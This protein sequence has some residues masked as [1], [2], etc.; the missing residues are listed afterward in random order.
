MSRELLRP[1]E[2]YQKARINFVQ[3][4][5]D[6][7]SKSQNIEALNAA[8]VMA[9]LRPLLLDTVPSIQQSAALAIG[10]L[11][12]YS[13][14]LATS[15]VENN[16]IP[17]LIF[18]LSKPNKFFKKVTC[19]VFK[20]VAKHSALL[21][22]EVVK[23][24]ALEP[25]V[26]CLDEFDTGV[27]EAAS[28]AL[29]F[30]AKHSPELAHKVIQARAVDSLVL[31]LQEPDL[32]LKRA[33][34]L[35]LSYI[36][37]HSEQLAKPVAEFGLDTIIFFLSY[38]DTQLK[39]NICQL[40]GNIARHSA[41]LAAQIIARIQNPQ[42]LLNCLKYPDDIVKKNAAFC[43]CELVNK[44][45]ENAQV[46]CDS[47]GAGILVDYITNVKGDARLYGILALGFIASFKKELAWTVIEAKA[48]NQLF[49]ALHNEINPQIKAAA[50]YSLGHIGRHSTKHAKEVSDANVLSLMLYY[51][52]DKK[53]NDYLRNKAKSS[54]KKII[55]NCDNLSA[56]EPLLQVSP[57]KILKHILN[58][59]IKY[60]KTNNTELKNFI[61][62]G[63]LQKLQ[64][65][66]FDEKIKASPIRAKLLRLINTIN[67]YYPPEIVKYYTP[68]DKLEEYEKAPEELENKG[69][70]ES[71]E[72]DNENSEENEIIK[73]TDNKNLDSNEKEKEQEKEK[74]TN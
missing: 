20:S 7:A 68:E 28:W 36:A 65:L 47:G 74:V 3:T 17:Q 27:K 57:D 56:L 38:N 51:Y 42:K 46:I 14:E 33:S 58:Q 24:G 71:N 49:D 40:L 67:S 25:L 62:N 13:E 35:T 1:F 11:A 52:Q 48:I 41:E 43:I 63:G 69:D 53:M 59:Y 55:N 70:E 30:I 5:A 32:L 26:E 8:G 44:S 21:A 18:S 73:L 15:V 22:E 16:I 60:L 9:L 61:Q 12:N 19:Y 31:C 4:I 37:S 66:R 45:P 23:S 72:S 29:G 10:R 64:E 54:L 39:R 6:L 34:A 50:C 2:E